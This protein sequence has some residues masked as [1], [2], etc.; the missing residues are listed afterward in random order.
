MI[1]FDRPSVILLLL[2]AILLPFL[3]QRRSSGHPALR[4]LPPDGLSRFVSLALPTAGAVALAALVLA[5][6]GP[7]LGG[8]TILREAIGAN[9]VLLFDRSSSMDNSF[10]NRQPNGDEESKSAVA[11]R[12]I[13]EFLDRRPKDRVGVAAFSTTPM[14]VMP[15]T[16]HLDAVRGAVSA[17]DKPG[18]AYTDVGRGL[19]LALGLFEENTDDAS[20]ALILISD[21]AGVIGR[22]VQDAL[23]AEVKRNPVNLYW[24]YIRSKGSYGLEDVPERKSDDTPQA[25]PERHL[26]KF[27]QSLGIPYLALEAQSP[28]AIGNAIAAIDRLESRPITYSEAIPRTELAPALYLLAAICLAIITGGV[29]IERRLMPS[30]EMPLPAVDEGGGA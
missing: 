30:G 28:E 29:A 8:G 1:A 3:R 4:L 2:P 17:I 23:R 9:I 13:L 19:I 11:K 7:S 24:L 25:R 27:L 21:G 6:S 5:L 16:D 20:R 10:A 26:H 12:L 15:L 22:E 18:L 14:F